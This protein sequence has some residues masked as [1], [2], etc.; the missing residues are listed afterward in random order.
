[1]KKVSAISEKDLILFDCCILIKL[2]IVFK[3]VKSRDVAY[4]STGKKGR[5]REEK[6]DKKVRKEQQERS[7]RWL[8]K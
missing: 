2:V 1:M 5:G 8:V 4:I 3:R 6:E 7:N